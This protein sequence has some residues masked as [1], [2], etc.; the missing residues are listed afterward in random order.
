MEGIDQCPSLQWD[1]KPQRSLD[2]SLIASFQHQG[3]AHSGSPAKILT[4]VNKMLDAKLWGHHI[5]IVK[6]LRLSKP[7]PTENMYV[8]LFELI[9]P[10]VAQR[11][12][13]KKKPTMESR[14]ASYSHISN[15]LDLRFLICKMT[16]SFPTT[17]L[18]IKVMINLDSILKN[19]DIILTT[20]FHLVKAMVF[21]VVM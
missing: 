17:L 18:E 13:K 11:G 15:C 6:P 4:S 5:S 14:E 16:A 20:K 2:V 10:D 1:P 19:R 21:P 8:W 9:K 3:L 12:E 7:E